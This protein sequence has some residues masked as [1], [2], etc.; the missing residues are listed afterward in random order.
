MPIE[1]IPDLLCL[2]VCAVATVTDVRSYRIPN[3]LTLSAAVV[4]FGLNA[5]L[6]PLGWLNS[7]AGGLLAATVFG[8]LGAA[9]F[10]GMGDVKLM[11][12]VGLMVRWPLALHTVMYVAVC[13]GVLA[14]GDVIRKRRVGNVFRNI[15]RL[16]GGLLRAEDRRGEVDLHRI[17]YGAAILA[18]SAWAVAARY[19]EVLRL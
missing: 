15:G 13:G 12:A 2:L 10:V 7:L 11:G 5:M 3:W 14:L 17:P 16:A 9:R 18:G 1:I 6:L 19:W 4:G 8:L